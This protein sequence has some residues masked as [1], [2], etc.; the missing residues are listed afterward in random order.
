MSAQ[1]FEE[2]LA[3]LYTNTAFREYFL[4]H[5]SRALMGCDLSD[6]ERDELLKIDKAGLVMASRSF[7]SKRQKRMGRFSSMAKIRKLISRLRNIW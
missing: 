5:P 6:D 1:A 7:Q 4:T 3:K 2:T